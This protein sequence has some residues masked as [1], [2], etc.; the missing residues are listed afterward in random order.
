V[1]EAYR[2]PALK[3]GERARPDGRAFQGPASERR[4]AFVPFLTPVSRPRWNLTL[5]R[6]CEEGADVL[7]LGVPFSDPSPDVLTRHRKRPLRGSTTLP[8]RPGQA[9]ARAR[10][11][12][13]IVS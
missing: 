3:T 12:T 5:P 10:H 1:R 8:T 9:I 2:R 13:P 7:E 4:F 6:I 11:E